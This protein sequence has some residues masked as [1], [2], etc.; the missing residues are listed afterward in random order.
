MK[1]IPSGGNILEW[2]RSGFCVNARMVYHFF[3][4]SAGVPGKVL[5]LIMNFFVGGRAV[6]TGRCSCMIQRPVSLKMFSNTHSVS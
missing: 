6:V 1:V 5:D 2:Q 3:T 4:H